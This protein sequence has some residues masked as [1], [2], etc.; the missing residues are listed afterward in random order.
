MLATAYLSFIYLFIITNI[1]FVLLNFDAAGWNISVGE[2]K[3]GTLCYSFIAP[4]YQHHEIN[5]GSGSSPIMYEILGYYFL[6]KPFFGA[7]SAIS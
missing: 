2:R 3:Q 6:L 7:Q 5:N 4:S 1:S